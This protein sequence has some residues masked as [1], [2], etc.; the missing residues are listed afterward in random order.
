MVNKK[1]ILR[2]IKNFGILGLALASLGCGNKTFK[3]DSVFKHLNRGKYIVEYRGDLPPALW[4]WV[5]DGKLGIDEFVIPLSWYYERPSFV[6]NR[7]NDGEYEPNITLSG[8]IVD[9][10]GSDLSEED[11]K[12][13][14]FS[15]RGTTC[16]M[17]GVNAYNGALGRGEINNLEYFVKG[18]YIG[19]LK[20]KPSKEAVYEYLREANRFAKDFAYERNKDAWLNYDISLEERA[21][22][23]ADF[24]FF[25]P[26][27]VQ[28]D[29][30]KTVIG[31]ANV[32]GK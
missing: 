13:R 15:S 24:Y 23:D 7:T 8:A 14:L 31:R 11:I 16:F 27:R 19:D 1:S 5:N 26:Y 20:G 9:F 32:V 21:N 2:K 25:G 29:S 30:I 4:F 18:F 17:N 10:S 12:S 22:R 6:F 3:E 28:G